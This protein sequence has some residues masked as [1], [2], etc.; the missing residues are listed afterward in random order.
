MDR[1][2]ATEQKVPDSN[3]NSDMDICI[4]LDSTLNGSPEMF[5]R[6]MQKMTVVSVINKPTF[7]WAHCVF[8]FERI[9]FLRRSYA[10]TNVNHVKIVIRDILENKLYIPVV[11]M[12]FKFWHHMQGERVINITFVVKCMKA[13]LLKGSE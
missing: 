5:N 6:D 9:G 3:P 4:E 2:L 13:Y 11:N 12:K 8:F 1:A 10:I 7:L